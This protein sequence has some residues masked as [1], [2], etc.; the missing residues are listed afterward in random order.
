MLAEQAATPFG[1]QAR[2]S[3]MQF[4]ANRRQPVND[5]VNLF[6]RVAVFQTPGR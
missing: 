5:L 2:A 6:N 3:V 1:A 4:T